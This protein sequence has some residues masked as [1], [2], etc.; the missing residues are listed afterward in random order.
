MQWCTCWKICFLQT[1]IYPHTGIGLKKGAFCLNIKV[2]VQILVQEALL[3]MGIMLWPMLWKIQW[4]WYFWP[5]IYN[6]FAYTKSSPPTKISIKC[7]QLV[8]INCGKGNICKNLKCWT[9]YALRCFS[10]VITKSVSYRKKLLQTFFHMLT[11]MLLVSR[12]LTTLKSH[13]KNITR[14]NV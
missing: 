2:S 13:L 7:S 12:L 11:A 10:N 3:D 14:H 9:N 4:W 1:K 6:C 5:T 8:A